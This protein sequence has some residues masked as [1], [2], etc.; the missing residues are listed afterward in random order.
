MEETTTAVPTIDNSKLISLLDTRIVD[1]SDIEE[2][3]DFAYLICQSA[4][5]GGMFISEN[6]DQQLLERV[7]KAAKEWVK[8]IR[9]RIA[10]MSVSNALEVIHVFDF[11][12][13]IAYSKPA[14]SAF[15]NKYTLQAFEARIQGNQSVN[16]YTLFRQINAGIK[17]CDPAYIDRPLRWYSISLERWHKEFKGNNHSAKSPIYDTIQKLN[18]LLE[19]DLW[20]Y[21]TRNQTA[22]KRQLFN[23]YS[24]LLADFDSYDIRTLRVL[25]TFVTT[26]HLLNIDDNSDD[27]RND[28]IEHLINKLPSTSFFKLMLTIQI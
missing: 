8:E 23:R 12:H 14:D 19:S 9:L 16:E 6:Q 18:I 4:S 17:R 26:I 5:Q 21:E 3:I 7:R 13:R 2:A 28:I 10:S 15:I 11:V 22:F 27:Y 25:H 20:I 24:Y 1:F